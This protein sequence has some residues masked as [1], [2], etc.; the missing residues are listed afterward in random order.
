MEKMNILRESGAFNVLIICLSL[1][2]LR[3]DLREI[4]ATGVSLMPEGL[5]Q[6]VTPQAI[7]DLIAFLKSGA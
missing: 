2:I 3:G 5:E 6:G 7:A 4:R 1:R